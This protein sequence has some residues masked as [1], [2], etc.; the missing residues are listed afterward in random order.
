MRSASLGCDGIPKGRDACVPGHMPRR[1]VPI[2]QRARL[3]GRYG[4][5]EAG[6]APPLGALPGVVCLNPEIGGQGGAEAAQRRQ[7]AHLADLFTQF[8]IERSIA[9]TSSLLRRF[10]GVLERGFDE[11]KDS[12]Q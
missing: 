5:E 8:E 2:K 10:Q 7:E 4:V 11:S 1:H 6:H 12:Q 9:Q 3:K